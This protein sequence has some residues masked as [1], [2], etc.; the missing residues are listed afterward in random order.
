MVCLYSLVLS[1][2]SSLGCLPLVFISFCVPLSP[3][4][5]AKAKEMSLA[6]VPSWERV[7]PCAQGYSSGSHSACTCC[8]GNTIYINSSIWFS[9]TTEVWIFSLMHIT[10]PEFWFVTESSSLLCTIPPLLQSQLPVDSLGQ[11]EHSSVPPY[12]ERQPLCSSL[13]ALGLTYTDPRLLLLLSGLDALT[14][15]C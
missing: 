1:L 14:L 5:H 6:E 2:S 3:H 7:A 8:S 4:I 13:R 9:F 12:M 10:G 11:W 15:S